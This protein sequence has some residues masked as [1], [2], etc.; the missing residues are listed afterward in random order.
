M[1]RNIKPNE[2]LPFE[3]GGNILYFTY[4]DLYGFWVISERDATH[5]EKIPQ[6][7]IVSDDR[8]NYEDAWDLA[9]CLAHLGYIG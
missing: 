6:P 8:L 9:D 3:V 1:N 4:T 2:I 7:K 5:V